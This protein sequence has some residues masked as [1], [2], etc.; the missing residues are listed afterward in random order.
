MLDIKD[1]QIGFEEYRREN[2]LAMARVG[3][4][5]YI[6][7]G[8][9][10]SYMVVDHSI[11]YLLAIR[12]FFILPVVVIYLLLKKQILKT[13]DIPI[14]I[15][16]C[17]AAI[18]ISYIAYLGGGLESDYYFGLV[19]VSFVQFTFVPMKLRKSVALDVLF[20]FIYFP[21]NYYSFET[22]ELLFIKQTSNYITFSIM[23]F[24]A[25]NRSRELIMSGFKNFSLEKELVHKERIQFLFGKLCHLLNNPLFISTGL[26]SKVD[27]TSLST[28]DK[29]RLERVDKASERMS[30]VLQRMGEL[31]YDED[32]DLSRYQEFFNDEDYL[33]ERE[34]GNRFPR[35]SK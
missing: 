1:A 28:E 11:W 22:P 33:G 10:D 3:V 25:V 30:K 7:L 4:P 8:Y 16:F 14:L 31:H 24:F 17:F 13:L 34:A 6:A 26:L 21:L 15:S 27:R 23:K 32:V 12:I 5:L 18:G 9:I 2:Y 35:S 19:I 20:F 29:E